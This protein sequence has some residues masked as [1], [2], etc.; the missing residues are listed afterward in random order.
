M[1]NQKFLLALAS[2]TAT[3][4]VSS[5]GDDYVGGRGSKKEERRKK[6]TGHLATSKNQG[7]QGREKKTQKLKDKSKHH[8][9]GHEEEE[10]DI[11]VISKAIHFMSESEVSV[12]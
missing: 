12:N 9:H 7:T 4:G 6:A 10:E 5:G 11:P 8:R 1:S 3:E 2:S